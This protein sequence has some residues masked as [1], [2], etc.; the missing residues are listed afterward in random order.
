MFMNEI[1]LNGK[2]A[3]A[4]L[5]NVSSISPPTPTLTLIYRSNIAPYPHSYPSTDDS[6]LVAKNVFSNTLAC[7]NDVSS[8]VSRPGG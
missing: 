2:S 5:A 6:N 4:A 7:V 1:I 8:S 3:F